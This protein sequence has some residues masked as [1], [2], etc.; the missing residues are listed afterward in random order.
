MNNLPSF[1]D[2]SI[3][4]VKI[5]YTFDGRIE[6]IIDDDSGNRIISLIA[7]NGAR[8]PEPITVKSD[9]RITPVKDNKF[10]DDISATELKE[11]DFVTVNIIYDPVT[12]KLNP[13]AFRLK[14][15][16]IQSEQ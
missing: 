14:L 11:N 2:K 9:F 15:P 8:F 7:G 5:F 13:S 12:K 6:K 10:L 1:D 16:R 4:G 3:V